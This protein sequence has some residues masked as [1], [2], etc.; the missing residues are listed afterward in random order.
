MKKAR[1]FWKERVIEEVGEFKYLGYKFQRNGGQEAQV[2]DW[3]RQ[4]R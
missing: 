2:K 4:R 1:W 3:R